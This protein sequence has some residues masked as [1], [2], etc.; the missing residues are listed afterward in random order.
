MKYSH[1]WTQLEFAIRCAVYGV[2]SRKE[3]LMEAYQN[4]LSSIIPKYDLPLEMRHSFESFLQAFVTESGE[5][6]IENFSIDD[7]T[8]INNRIVCF[9]K[10]LQKFLI[11]NAEKIPTLSKSV[12]AE[13]A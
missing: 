7:I 1:A 11:K 2:G 3:R 10:E 12:E 4:H 6:I 13:E 8:K 5:I 9:Q